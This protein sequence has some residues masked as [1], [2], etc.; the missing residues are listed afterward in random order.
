MDYLMGPKMT[1]GIRATVL[2]LVTSVLTAACSLG[3]IE[4]PA[5]APSPIVSGDEAF[6]ICD[7]YDPDVRAGWYGIATNRGTE[8]APDWECTGVNPG[9]LAG[10]DFNLITGDDIKLGS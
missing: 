1:P 4:G 2:V 9:D 6:R 7:M 10:P 5:T 3:F 8:D